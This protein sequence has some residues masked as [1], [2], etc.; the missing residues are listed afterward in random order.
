MGRDNTITLRWVPGHEG[1]AGNEKADEYA[2]RGARNPCEGTPSSRRHQSVASTAFLKRA[3]AD[4]RREETTAWIRSRTAKSRA[5]I[6]PRTLRFREKLRNEKKEVAS[7]YFQFLTGHAL[8]APYLKEKL[9][10]RGIQTS[11]GGVSRASGRPGSTSSLPSSSVRR[12]AI[13]RRSSS[14]SWGG[15][16]VIESRWSFYM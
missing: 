7:R 11:V 16:I 8:M 3:A 14:G 13:M 12:R 5:Y 6:P 15:D 2:K 10:K 9:K 4:A 1:I